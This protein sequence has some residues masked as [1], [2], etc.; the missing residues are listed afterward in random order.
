MQAHIRR[1]AADLHL[2]RSTFETTS[3]LGR[4]RQG[5]NGGATSRAAFLPFVF[6]TG[7]DASPIAREA[8]EAPCLEKPVPPDQLIDELSG[9]RQEARRRFEAARMFNPALRSWIGYY[10][11]YHE[12]ALSPVFRQLNL[13]LTTWVMRK[14]KRFKGH[15]RR[16]SFWLGH[17]ARRQPTLFAHWQLLGV[18]PTA[19]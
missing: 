17:V 7:Y 5:T 19:G 12:S 16:A 8:P 10:G 1:A 4:S 15:R 18:K 3:A 14:Y 13:I 9:A 6:T 2:A 11:S